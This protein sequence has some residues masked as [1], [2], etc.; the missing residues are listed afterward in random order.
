MRIACFVVMAACASAASSQS[1]LIRHDYLNSNTE[2]FSVSKKGD[3]T[4]LKKPVAREHQNVKLEVTNFNG[5]VW[6]AETELT[7]ESA[8]GGQVHSVLEILTGSFAG[9]ASG[10]LGLM[11]SGAAQGG[12]GFGEAGGTTDQRALLKV[13]T[14]AREPFLKAYNEL[15]RVEEALTRI[16]LTTDRLLHL[17]YST[18]MPSDAI[19]AQA[20]DAIRQVFKTA[21]SPSQADFTQ[22]LFELRNAV[23]SNRQKAQGAGAF[24]VAALKNVASRGDEATRTWL[25]QVLGTPLPQ[26]ILDSEQ[27][28]ETVKDF[29]KQLAAFGLEAK[30]GRMSTYY[31]AI[32]M[33]DFTFHDNVIAEEDYATLKFKVFTNPIAAFELA[34]ID[35][36]TLVLENQQLLQPVRTK[37][38]R[39]TVAGGM[40]VT[41]SVG[42]SFPTFGEGSQAFYNK[43]S[44]ITTASASNFIPN[45]STFLHFYP[46][47]GRTVSYAGSFGIGVP[48][49]NDGFSLNFMLGA[50]ALIGGAQ[51]ICVTAGVVS[52]PL[53]RLELGYELGDKL[54][55][56]FTPV[57]T[58]KV[59]DLG[60]FA[61][62]SF[63]L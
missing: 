43:D 52:G 15:I 11:M 47:T 57:P 62:L 28:L 2:Y 46:F 17:K 19:K 1:L 36:T 54:E 40:K 16:D 61:G 50:S 13:I 5:F 39:V 20:D 56:E 44:I 33:S 49:T 27:A 3:T 63:S 35:T 53:N 48:V 30:L 18:T 21:Q 51:K 14:D 25:G 31:D 23:E 32:R 7:T 55:S 41:A 60:A 9:Q 37:S 42:L 59:Y 26:L 24:Y 45:V 29:D 8:P 12:L 58:R 34:G 4:R 38:F 10:I 6:T 22:M